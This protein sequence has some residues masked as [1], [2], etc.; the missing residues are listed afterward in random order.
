MLLCPFSELCMW[1]LGRNKVI[2][3][4]WDYGVVECRGCEN[5]K[6]G[7]KDYVA[8]TIYKSEWR[9]T[10]CSQEVV[11]HRHYCSFNL[12]IGFKMKKKG[13]E[14]KVL[15]FSFNFRVF[16]FTLGQQCSIFEALSPNSKKTHQDNDPKLQ[17]SKFLLE[18]HRS[19][20]WWPQQADFSLIGHDRWMAGQSLI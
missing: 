6:Q 13:Y 4:L 10:Q 14:V 19:I 5:R 8:K 9:G 16:T 15:T 3:N 12:K 2:T 7:P 1:P 17:A 18:I 11:A 20:G